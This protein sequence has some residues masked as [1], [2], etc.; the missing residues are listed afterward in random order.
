MIFIVKVAKTVRNHWKKSIFFTGVLTY[1]VIYTKNYLQTQDLM[2]SYCQR[3]AK[4]GKEPIA[5]NDKPRH[6]TVILNPNANKRKSVDEFEKYCAP[7]LHLAGISVEVKK[8]ESEGHAKTLIEEIG[9][10]DAIVIAGGDGTLSEVVTGLLRKTNDNASNIPLGVLPLGKTNTVATVKFPGKT[11]VERVKALA[12]A[13]MA[14]IEDTFKP[15]DVMKIEVLSTEIPEQSNKPIYAVGSLKWGAYRDAK[16]NKDSYWYFGPLRNYAT[17]IFNG[18]KKKLSWDCEALISYSV[19]C[20]GCSNCYRR[21]ENVSKN[22]GF[23]SRFVKSENPYAKYL[24]IYNPE[25]SIT[26]EKKI[27]TSDLELSTLNVIDGSSSETPSKLV[28]EIGPD[29]I[30]YL[31][32]VKNGFK[33][34]KGEK[35]DVRE[36]IEA[37]TVNINP[38]IKAQEAWFSIDNENYE[39]KPIKV[40]LLPK[41]INMFYKKENVNVYN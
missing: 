2:R 34:E 9:G 31:D 36:F 7:L 32:F 19:P 41:I 27:H 33:L 8:T 21:S 30:E 15:I 24:S 20:E 6:I 35:K 37:R 18:F 28:V 1:G 11:K 39:V 22:G 12:E 3:A 38:E 16:A 14:V 26:H 23:F 4:Y 5:I 17:Y 29:N 13:A 10:T 40:T 25:C